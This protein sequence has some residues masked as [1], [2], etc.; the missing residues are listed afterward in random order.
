MVFQT[1]MTNYYGKRK[2]RQSTYGGKRRYTGGPYVRRTAR[3]PGENYW[4]RKRGFKPRRSYRRNYVRGQPRW[5]AQQRYETQMYRTK[6]YDSPYMELI[7][8]D[9]SKY[10]HQAD[11]KM[12]AEDRIALAHFI[13]DALHYRQFK[14]LKRVTHWWLADIGDRNLSDY[15]PAEMVYVY[16]SEGVDPNLAAIPWD[17]LN[18]QP[19]SKVSRVELGKKYTW[20]SYPRFQQLYTF[21]DGGTTFPRDQKTA[22]DARFDNPWWDSTKAQTKDDIK[23]LEC[24][25]GLRISVWDPNPGGFLPPPN[26]TVPRSPNQVIRSYDEYTIQWRYPR[27]IV[28][29]PAVGDEPMIDDVSVNIQDDYVDMNEVT[30]PVDNYVDMNEVTSPYSPIKDE[31]DDPG[32]MSDPTNNQMC[33]CGLDF[34]CTACE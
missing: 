29:P 4:Y 32:Y 8:S 24:D 16:D 21:T 34:T 19:G 13:D 12:L 11:L 26:N 25:N 27:R 3:G 2:G 5:L 20:T 22:R 10:V 30:S 18:G 28:V 7:P 31:P 33:Y 1:R 23:K 15:K 14:I 6:T 9:E 17:Q